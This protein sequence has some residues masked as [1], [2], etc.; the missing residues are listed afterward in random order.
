M[1]EFNSNYIILKEHNV[2]LEYH[3]GQF[4][5]QSFINTKHNISIQPDFKPDLK[6]FVNLQDVVFD[7]TMKDI[8]KYVDFLGSNNNI[9]GQ[10]Q[11]A[12]ITRT[13]NQVVNT[14]LF[15]S[16]EELKNKAIEIFSTNETAF[17]WLDIKHLHYKEF[18]L[19]LESLKPAKVLS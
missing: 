8:Q 11:V 17:D 9:L 10:R 13:P 14:T 3:S 5:I 2:V 12:I 19:L 15:K 18:Q 1:T 4:D 16:N 6:S 7:I